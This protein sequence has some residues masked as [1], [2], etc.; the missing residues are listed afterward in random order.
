MRLS[1]PIG[2]V[3]LTFC[4]TAVVRTNRSNYF[5]EFRLVG[6]NSGI[7][8]RFQSGNF[9]ALS[10]KEDGEEGF[11]R[12]CERSSSL[13]LRIEGKC[14][15]KICVTVEM[16]KRKIGRHGSR[17]KLLGNR[18]NNITRSIAKLVGYFLN[19][20]NFISLSNIELSSTEVGGE[21]IRD[22]KIWKEIKVE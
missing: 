12:S 10:R 18:V 11:R 4:S 8:N 6:C 22:K 15:L 20:E 2:H 1:T 5:I 13:F 16:E 7:Y 19:A 9:R 21:R 3:P 17:R 14:Y